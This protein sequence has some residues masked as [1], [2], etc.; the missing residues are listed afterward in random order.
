MNKILKR[1]TWSGAVGI[2]CEPTFEDKG[3]DARGIHPGRFGSQYPRMAFFENGTW[4]I[5]YTVYRNNGYLADK[6][7]NGHR[8]AHLQRRRL[9]KPWHDNPQRRSVKAPL[10]LSL[11]A[12]CQQCDDTTRRDDRRCHGSR[13]WQTGSK[14][15]Q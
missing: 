15:G 1:I 8:N 11:P 10:S 13:F 6:R 7:R 9:P 12:G 4:L 14:M 5:V 2:N 3:A